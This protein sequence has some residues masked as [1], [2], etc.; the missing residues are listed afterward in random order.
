MFR[1]LNRFYYRNSAACIFVVDV[2]SPD[3]IQELEVWLNEYLEHYSNNTNS[4]SVTTD[5]NSLRTVFAIF[6]TKVDR[7]VDEMLIANQR[8][9]GGLSVDSAVDRSHQTADYGAT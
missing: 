5:D 8:A 3:Y 2:Q 1:S 6:V 7:V 9:G 4:N